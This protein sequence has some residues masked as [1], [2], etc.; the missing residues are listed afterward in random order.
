MRSLPVR[1][2]VVRVSPKRY[3]AAR[4]HMKVGR[5]DVMLEDWDVFGPKFADWRQAH[6]HVVSVMTPSQHQEHLRDDYS[7]DEL[8]RLTVAC[9]RCGAKPGVDCLRTDS[10]GRISTQIDPHD[11][12]RSKENN[13]E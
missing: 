9:P 7:D 13:S 1:F 6:D 10:R 12:R 4:T 3:Q 11:E 8:G 2:G 5:G